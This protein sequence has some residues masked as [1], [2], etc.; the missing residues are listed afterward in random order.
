[1]LLPKGFCHA[2]MRPRSTPLSQRPKARLLE[3]WLEDSKD[4]VS[5]PVSGQEQR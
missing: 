1:M 2:G 4:L 5:G 3:V